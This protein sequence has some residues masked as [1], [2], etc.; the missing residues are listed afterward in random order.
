MRWERKTPLNI[1]IANTLAS[2]GVRTMLHE[3]AVI[4]AFITDRLGCGRQIHWLVVAF[5][6]T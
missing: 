6:E 2:V 1:G 5:P 3:F 4:I